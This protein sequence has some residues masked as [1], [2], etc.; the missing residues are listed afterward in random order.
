MTYPKV[1]IILPVLN[2]GDNLR[3][4][5]SL[6]FDQ[7]YPKEKLDVIVVDNGSND[8]SLEL[9]EVFDGVRLILNDQKRSPYISRNLAI[10]NLSK[11]SELVIFLDTN[12]LPVL[13]NWIKI[14][15]HELQEKS[16]QVLAAD[17]DYSFQNDPPKLLALFDSYKYTS[18]CPNIVSKT[19]FPLS[20]LV[21]KREVINTLGLFPEVR[22][23]GDII[24]TQ[25]IFDNNFSVGCSQ[26]V[27]VQYETRSGFAVF[28]KA[29][30]MGFGNKELYRLGLKYDNK[31]FLFYALRQLLPPSP[32]TF[33][34]IRQNPSPQIRGRVF[35]FYLL[36]Y[37]YKL[38]Y[39][40]GILSPKPPREY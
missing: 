12:K 19:A 6:I 1:S 36:S 25:L 17:I 9:L 26:K 30:R 22:S 14:S 40:V 20:L 18:P 2:P 28:K 35:N 31:S 5:L 13:K 4:C 8:G 7:G 32:A 23:L 3:N 38:C 37:C 33:R 24:W 11:D 15:I 16:V 39:F 10:L 34:K 21:C 29:V 27:S